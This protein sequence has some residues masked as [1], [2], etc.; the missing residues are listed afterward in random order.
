MFENLM[1]FWGRFA[2][3]TSKVAHKA[4]FTDCLY[5]SAPD[6]AH[7]PQKSIKNGGR[8]QRRVRRCGGS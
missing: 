3:L 2:V 4:L 6:L 5:T 8:E 7:F 1:L